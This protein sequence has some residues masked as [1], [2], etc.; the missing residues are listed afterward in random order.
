MIINVITIRIIAPMLKKCLVCKKKEQ[1]ETK[2]FS[3]RMIFFTELCSERNYKQQLFFCGH[4]NKKK[5]I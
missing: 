3:F 4:I 1:L 5:E 2:D